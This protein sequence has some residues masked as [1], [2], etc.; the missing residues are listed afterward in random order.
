MHTPFDAKL[1]NF[2]WQPWGWA[3]FRGQLRPNWG[4]YRAYYT[5]SPHCFN[6]GT[7]VIRHQVQAP[8][9]LQVTPCHLVLLCRSTSMKHSGRS[10][11][12]DACLL[13]SSDKG[14]S[15]DLRVYQTRVYE[16]FQAA[17]DRSVG[18][19]EHIS[20]ISGA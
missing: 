20:V 4:I 9:S 19:M 2:T 12:R 18:C 13:M 14:N 16:W 3:C 15:W 17:S 1:R 11:R 5:I 8:D 10:S 6:D 7:T